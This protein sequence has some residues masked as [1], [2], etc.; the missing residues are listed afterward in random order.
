M[1]AFLRKMSNKLLTCNSK[2]DIMISRK[3]NTA[4]GLKTKGVK[5]ARRLQL[6]FKFLDTEEQAQLFC[7][8]INKESSHYCRTKY[9]AHYTPW[10]SSDQTEHKFIAWYRY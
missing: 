2:R 9:P 10:T 1:L 7:D 6:T 4:V 3:T 5:M 8:A